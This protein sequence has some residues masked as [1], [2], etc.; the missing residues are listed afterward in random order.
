MCNSWTLLLTEMVNASVRHEFLH[1]LHFKNGKNWPTLKH[2]KFHSLFQ[3]NFL[4]LIKTAFTSGCCCLKTSNEINDSEIWDVFISHSHTDGWLAKAYSQK[5]F[6]I[7]S[8]VSTTLRWW[9]KGRIWNAKKNYSRT[10]NT[11]NVY[12]P[13]IW[14]SNFVEF[15]SFYDHWVIEFNSHLH[16]YVHLQYEDGCRVLQWTRENF[17]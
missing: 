3:L 16:V 17:E 13:E 11:N 14:K 8:L 12:H 6:W 2:F 9:K 15:I 1:F 5:Y 10:H 4:K 7:N